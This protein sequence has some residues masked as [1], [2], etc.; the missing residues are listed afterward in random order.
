LSL[1]PRRLN[2]DSNFSMATFYASRGH[3]T[4]ASQGRG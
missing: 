3:S 1:R 4:S 2:R